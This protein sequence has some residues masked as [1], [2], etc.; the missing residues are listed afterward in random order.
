MRAEIVLNKL[1]AGYAET[2]GKPGEKVT[3]SHAGFF[4]SEDGDELIR[5]LEGFPQEI[6]SSIPSNK[7]ILPSMIDTLL[8]LIRKNKT[9]SVYLNDVSIIAKIRVKKSIKKGELVSTN[10][11]LDFG[12][13]NFQDIQ[14]PNDAGIIFVFSTGWRKGFFYDL[15][16]L[17]GAS[18]ILRSYDLE[19]TLGSLYSYL[20]FQERFK[21]SDSAWDNLFS[22]KWFP[23]AYLN[24]TLIKEMLVYAKEGWNIDDLL[25]KIK[26]N[27]LSLVSEAEPFEEKDPIFAEHIEILKHAIDKYKNEDHIS[28]VSILYPRIEGLMRSFYRDSGYTEAP[29][30]VSLTK[31]VIEHYQSER[32]P[33]SL[34]LPEKFQN[35]LRRIYFSNFA[36]GSKPDVGRHSVAHGEARIDDFSLKSSS[37]AILVLYQLSLFLKGNKS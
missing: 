10:N 7:P 12:E 4:S 31:A 14:V 3:V 21:I 32:I 20:L 29:S 9:V 13:I 30:S 16:P 23:F 34:L 19:K 35:Y 11:V 1:P 6:I 33:Q 8:A 15:A 27:I 28:C 37:I 26:E 5:R 17:N 24:E 18:P 2:T 36:P 22:Q 25:P